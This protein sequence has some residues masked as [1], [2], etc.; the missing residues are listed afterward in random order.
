MI[1]AIIGTI[2][3]AAAIWGG[4]QF[5]NWL[6]GTDFTAEQFYNTVAVLALFATNKLRVRNGGR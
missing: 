5:F 3:D 4:L 1:L 6:G 2:I